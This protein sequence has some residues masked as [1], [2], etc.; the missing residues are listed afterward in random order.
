MYHHG[1]F[2]ERM[3]KTVCLGGSSSFVDWIGIGYFSMFMLDDISKTVGMNK[4][5]RFHYSLLGPMESYGF[6]I[7]PND[8]E[9]IRM[10][11]HFLDD[12]TMKSY[13]TKA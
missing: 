6:Y 7:L 1:D 5:Y 10:V 8:K 4:P 3:W 13:I 9:C 11:E 12:K 2:Y